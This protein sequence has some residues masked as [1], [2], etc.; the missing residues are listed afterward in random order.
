MAGGPQKPIIFFTEL[1]ESKPQMRIL[2][3][4]KEIKL[5]KKEN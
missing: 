1:V 2:E 4:K 3:Y 5:Q